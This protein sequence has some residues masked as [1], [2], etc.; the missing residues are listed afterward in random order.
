MRFSNIYLT[1]AALC[2]G[3]NLPGMNVFAQESVE[4][5]IGMPDAVVDLRTREGVD[6]L[7]SQWRYSDARIVGVDFNTPGSKGPD[8]LKLYP[9]G[10]SIKTNDIAPKAGGADF[11][12]SQWQV[13]DPLSLSFALLTFCLCSSASSLAAQSGEVKL[14]MA[15]GKE[16]ETILNPS[17]AHFGAAFKQVVTAKSNLFLLGAGTAATLIARP[18]DD[19]ISRELK[20]DDFGEF[21]VELPNALGSFFVVAGATLFTHIIGR[22]TK[23]GDL[24]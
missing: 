14:P 20:E 17:V 6:L 15:R 13:L 21:E 7:N 10:K 23:K 3:V 8:K 4:L 18:F 16:K 1:I 12:D 5:A 19:D 9:T 11:A 2:L 24:G 22:A